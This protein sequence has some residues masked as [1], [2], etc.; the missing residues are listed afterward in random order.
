MTNSLA[1]QCPLYQYWACWDD[2]YETEPSESLYVHFGSYDEAEAYA[3]SLNLP[4]S[5]IFLDTF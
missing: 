5:N 2:L 1:T 4:L 3:L